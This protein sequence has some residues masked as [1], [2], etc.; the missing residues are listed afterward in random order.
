MTESCT[1]SRLVQKPT[2]A[3]A[4]QNE[5]LQPSLCSLRPEGHLTRMTLLTFMVSMLPQSMVKS[6]AASNS[7]SRMSAKNGWSRHCSAVGRLRW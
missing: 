5:K 2:S 4:H 1:P 3:K 6:A 7:G